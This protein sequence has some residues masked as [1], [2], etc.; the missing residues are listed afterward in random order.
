MK[1]L[2]SS[3][4]LQLLYVAGAPERKGQV[5]E[6]QLPRAFCFITHPDFLL[7]PSGSHL[8]SSKHLLTIISVSHISQT[9]RSSS[10]QW[11]ANLVHEVSYS[12]YVS[13]GVSQDESMCV[14]VCFFFSCTLESCSLYCLTSF[15]PSLALPGALAAVISMFSFKSPWKR[16]EEG[17]G[18]EEGE[19]LGAGNRF[20]R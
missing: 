15:L 1:S 9:H 3:G 6:E 7:L 17:D 5:S 2:S 16:E 19:G 12:Y 13:I 10:T 14:C 11:A 4:S 8:F 20:L 18:L